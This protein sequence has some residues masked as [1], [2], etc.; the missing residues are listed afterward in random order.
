[1]KTLDSGIEENRIYSIHEGINYVVKLVIES[2]EQKENTIYHVNL[3][4]KETYN[5]IEQVKY[6]KIYNEL[7]AEYYTK[8]QKE[9][10]NIERIEREKLE[11]QQRFEKEK[12]RIDELIRQGY[13]KVNTGT[14]LYTKDMKRIIQVYSK[15]YAKILNKQTELENYYYV[16]YKGFKG[17]VSKYCFE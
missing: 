3:F 16:E 10:E 15:T 8:E 1:M 4:H 2:E 14:I 17:Y 6:L 11:E 13:S 5:S 9:K 7:L 12:E